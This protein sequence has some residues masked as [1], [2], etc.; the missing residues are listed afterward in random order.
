MIIKAIVYLFISGML[1]AGTEQSRIDSV[2]TLPYEYIVSNIKEAVSK[3]EKNLADARTINYRA[4]EADALYKLGLAKIMSGDYSEAASNYLAAGAI[5]EE[6]GDLVNLAEVYGEYGYH[7]KRHDINQAN[8][9]MRMGISVAEE[10]NFREVL[11]KLYDNYGVIKEMEENTDSAL[12]YY[13]KGLEIKEEIQDTI[14]IPYS[15]NNL[16]GIMAM[17]GRKKDALDYIALSGEYR[18]KETGEYGRT[19]N[20][21]LTADIYKYFND[22]DSAQYYFN[23]AIKPAQDLHNS[24]MLAYIYNNLSDIYEQTGNYKEAYSYY[25]D[26]KALEDSISNA[27]VQLKIAGLQLDYETEKKDRLIARNQLEINRRDYMIYITSGTLFF[28]I[29]LSYWIYRNQKLKREKIKNE[30]ELKEKLRTAELQK[31]ITEEKYRISRDLHDNI[32]SRMTFMISSLDNLSYKEAADMNDKLQKLGNFGRNTLADLR[33]TVWALKLD[34]GNINNLVMKITEFVHLYN[35]DD[36]GIKTEF[37]HNINNNVPLTANKI[38][39]IYRIVQEAVQNG[40][41]HSGC[42][43]IKIKLSDESG[44]LELNIEDNGKGIPDNFREGNGIINMR[45]RCEESGG[46]FEISGSS[47]GTKI[48]CTFQPD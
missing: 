41:K 32:G 1:L 26:Y 5:Y 45:L 40:I 38:L 16:A 22:Y 13:N 44:N 20:L 34:D 27:D 9:Y 43:V 33:N 11:A 21:L 36:T 35:H 29:I 39:N 28:M 25:R 7:I 24:A 48:K 10:E 4:G 2:N 6:L 42:S 12:Y 47:S 30:L 17:K 8:I 31:K 23:K 3:L 15:L 46:N 14:G 18:K 19:E 37:E